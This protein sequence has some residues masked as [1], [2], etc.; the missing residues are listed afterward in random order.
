MG[1]LFFVGNTIKCYLT[2]P[3]DADFEDEEM[4]DNE[5]GSTDLN[6]SPN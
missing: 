5:I 1:F 4:M 3:R 6:S 2:R